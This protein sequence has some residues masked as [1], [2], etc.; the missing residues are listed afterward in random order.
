MIARNLIW[1]SSRDQNLSL[2]VWISFQPQQSLERNSDLFLIIQM[3]VKPSY[4]KSTLLES[5]WK[6]TYK[7]VLKKQGSKQKKCRIHLKYVHVNINTRLKSYCPFCVARAFQTFKIHKI[8]HPV[9]QDCF[10][11]S[12]FKGQGICD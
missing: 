9:L 8:A 7:T 3:V 10:Y 2:S 11:G 4:P 1:S 6:H 5:E 12:E